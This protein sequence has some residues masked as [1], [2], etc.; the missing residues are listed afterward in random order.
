MNLAPLAVQKF[1]DNNGRPLAGGLLFTYAAGTNNKLATYVDSSGGTPNTNP[2]E[3]DFRGECD[4][5]LDP[6]LT[7]K[8]VLAPPNDT[9]PPTNPIWSVDN[10][11][12]AL[13]YADLIALL[14]QQFIGLVL[15]PR[16]AEEIAAGVTPTYYFYP[17][18]DILRYGADP[19]GVD[20]SSDSIESAIAVAQVGGAVGHN[21]NLYPI[22]SGATAFVSSGNFVYL[23]KGAYRITRTLSITSSIAILGVSAA[24]TVIGY[25]GGSLTTSDYLFEIGNSPTGTSRLRPLLLQDFSLATLDFAAHG[26]NAPRGIHLIDAHSWLINRVNFSSLYLPIYAIDSWVG[27]V[28]GCMFIN[29][30]VGHVHFADQMHNVDIKHNVFNST[31]AAFADQPDSAQLFVRKSYAVTIEDNDFEFA[32]GNNILLN[33]DCRSVTV[34]GNYFESSASGRSVYIWDG[35]SGLGCLGVWITGNF[36]NTNG[37]PITCRIT[38]GTPTPHE[39]IIIEGNYASVDAAQY[40]VLVSGTTPVVDSSV[41]NN[42]IAQGLGQIDRSAD[43]GFDLDWS[44]LQTGEF[45]ATFTGF[46]TAQTAT[47]YWSRAGENVTV[48]FPNVF[49]TSNAT[50]FTITG[51]PA[52][53]Q[54]PTRVGTYG[55]TQMLVAQDNGA[56]TIATAILLEASSTITLRKGAVT[57]GGAWTAALQKGVQAFQMTWSISPPP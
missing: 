20:D 4:V 40:L 49:A 21:G 53:L 7:Y 9:D 27:A 31:F 1:F 16:T 11:S 8:F 13:S 12:S 42:V 29:N 41:Q 38:N 10:I 24:S 52:E 37:L 48:A 30:Y 36:I 14:T 2:I 18:G 33:N 55:A 19:T 39:G 43:T 44:F 35:N 56:D 3:L 15:Y 46:S 6:T 17:P 32:F 51:L 28:T 50:T 5:W 57:S 45:T 22:N 47:A 54:I 34:T 25:S 23:P 26:A